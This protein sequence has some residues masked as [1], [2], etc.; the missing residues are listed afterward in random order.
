[1]FYEYATACSD[2]LASLHEEM[3]FSDTSVEESETSDLAVVCLL[4][5]GKN[6]RFFS[7]PTRYLQNI[8]CYTLLLIEKYKPFK[9]YQGTSC[10]D[11][12]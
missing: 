3:I 10:V 11:H 12:I 9:P 5:G 1:M 7:E 2:I 4:V 8:H 6:K